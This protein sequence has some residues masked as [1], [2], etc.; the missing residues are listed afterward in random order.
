MFAIIFEYVL[1]VY[2]WF[3]RHWMSNSFLNWN[4]FNDISVFSIIFLFLAPCQ[5]H[6]MIKYIK[7]Y[8][9]C[10]VAPQKQRY[11][12]VF[13]S[14]H[15]LKSVFQ[16]FGKVPISLLVFLYIL[17]TYWYIFCLVN[18]LHCSSVGNSWKLVWIEFLNSQ[19][20][21]GWMWVLTGMIGGWMKCTNVSPSFCLL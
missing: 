20:I 4:K 3:I 14:S 11:F 9:L 13:K 18:H 7:V 17:A 21:D 8:L 1:C 5:F 19:F 15:W 12:L 16:T 6:Y 2:F 10:T